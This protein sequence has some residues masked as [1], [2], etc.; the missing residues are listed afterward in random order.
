MSRFLI[1]LISSAFCVSAFAATVEEASTQIAEAW[2]QHDSMKATLKVQGGPPTGSNRVVLNAEGTAQ[3]LKVEGTDRYK[4]NLRITFA[5]GNTAS[6]QVETVFDGE[7]LHISNESLGRKQSREG[8]PGLWSG[9][10]PP[11]GQPLLDA[12]TAAGD[13]EVLP[14]ETVNETEAFVLAGRAK[15]KEASIARFRAHVAK[16]TGALL[17]LDLYESDTVLTATIQQSEFEWGVEFD[18]A[19]F[20][21]PGATPAAE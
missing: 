21:A 7:K 6:M 16:D 11:G 1:A 10:V 2:N 20:S 4:Q 18:A 9:A 13:L 14:D 8:E 15:D 5:G 19:A 12:L 3:A 17:K